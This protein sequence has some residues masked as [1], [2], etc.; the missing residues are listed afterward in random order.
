[1]ETIKILSPH[2]KQTNCYIIVYL[3]YIKQLIK[4]INK[5]YSKDILIS[6]IDKSYFAH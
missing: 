3:K 4:I 5:I 2:Y 1:M 6:S